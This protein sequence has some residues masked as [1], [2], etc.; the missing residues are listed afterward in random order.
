[1]ALLKPRVDRVAPEPQPSDDRAPDALAAGVAEPLASE[2]RAIVGA[3]GLLGRASDLVRYASDA[4][5]YRKLP[6]AVVRPRDVGQ[7]AA[8]EEHLG[9]HG[10]VPVEEFVPAL[11]EVALADGGDGLAA[12]RTACRDAP[13][14]AMAARR[15]G[16]ARNHHDFVA[17]RPKAHHLAHELGHGFEVQPVAAGGQQAGA[18]LGDDAAIAHAVSR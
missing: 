14:Q 16:A 18:E 9:D 4:S 7:V 15:L 5:P 3:D 1:M 2:L 8:G 17:G 12:G 10:V 11:H 6:Q 13:A